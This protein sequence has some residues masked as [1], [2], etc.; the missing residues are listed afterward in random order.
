[1]RVRPSIAV[2]RVRRSSEYPNDLVTWGAVTTRTAAPWLA[3]G[4]T[5]ASKQPSLHNQF[6]ESQ[7]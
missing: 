4:F 5:E 6:N 3:I 7:K 2:L 1:M